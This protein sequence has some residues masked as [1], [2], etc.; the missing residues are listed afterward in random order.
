M[1]HLPT[2]I[3]DLSM[4]LL[5]AGI[6]TILFKKLHQPLVLGYII[7]GFIT[8]PN[9]HFFPTVVDSTNIST[10]SEIG[11]IFLMFALGLE[12]SFYKLKSVGSTAFIATAIAVGGMIVVGYTCGTLL[13]WSHM[14]SLFLGGMLSMSSTAIII[15]AFDDMKLKDECFAEMVMGVLII[16]DI[17]GIV[18][19]V[20]LSTLGAATSGVSTGA[21][22]AGVGKLIFCLV[23]WFV[24]GMY[25]IPTFFK[26]T[27]DIMNEETLLVA[28]IGL[29]LGMVVLAA[30]MGFSSALGAFIM[31]SLIAEAPNA[32]EIEHLVKP[33][34]DLF[35]AVFFV[36]VGML[37]NPAMLL[38]YAG[39]VCV[40]IVVTIVGQITMATIGMLAAGQN[41]HT[42]MRCGFSL[43]QIGEFSFIIASLGTSLKVTS[44][45]LYPIIVAVSVITT[46]TTPFCIMSSEKAYNTISKLL[47]QRILNWLS[48]YTDKYN[49]NKDDSDWKKLLNIYITR[50]GIYFTLLM[51][52]SIGA[53]SYLLPYLEDTLN[54]S[55]GS[56]IAGGI[57]LLVMSPILRAVLINRAGNADLFSIL[58]FKR[59]SNHFPLLVLILGKLSL[60][61]F[62]LH[63]VFSDIMGLHSLMSLLAI[64]GACYLISSSDWLMGEYLRIESRF[65]VNLNEKHMRKHY[66]SIGGNAN[67]K[68]SW[69]DEDLQLARYKVDATSSLVGKNMIQLA[70]RQSFGCNVLQITNTHGSID[71][72]GGNQIVEE[73]SRL[74]M[75]GTKS[76][77]NALNAGIG[78]YKYEM[79]LEKAA[80]SLRQFMLEQDKSDKNEADNFLSCA[81]TID[82]HSEL[83]GK[84]IKAADLR[85]KWHCLVI[86][87]E[88]GD[89]TFTNPN[90]SL[91]FEEGDLLWVLG[92]QEMINILIREEIL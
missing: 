1:T 85:T 34:K 64:I 20:M 54:H 46:F 61:A 41:L 49:D 26:R 6:T 56:Y 8:G 60:A 5:V 59:R 77:L 7:A 35:G 28:S 9:F 18:M 32:D 37:V 42:A 45:F 16:E 76:Q 21:I 43:C 40:L 3:T 14:N 74:L 65:L 53:K 17:A 82:K 29:C 25:L 23:L 38:E 70:F 87:L 78:H 63:V 31:G 69:F 39:P 67:S 57:T 72:P 33:V 55:Y 24:L 92:K 2:I 58:W 19:L 44:D 30:K 71:M 68:I 62:F 89:Y 84:T 79:H 86:G 27:R 10:W 90:V 48:R 83:L 91:V 51:A 11:V 47:P 50:M 66:E 13:G 36:S 81:I 75:I 73:E 88:R 15:K 22:L 52:I 80:V 4:I 12:F